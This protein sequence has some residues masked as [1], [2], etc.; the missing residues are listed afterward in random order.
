MCNRFLIESYFK[1][2]VT[3]NVLLC[4]LLLLRVPCIVLCV[5]LCMR[6]CVAAD[7][8]S[9]LL[10]RKATRAVARIQSAGVFSGFACCV[11]VFVCVYMCLCQKLIECSH[12]YSADLCVCFVFLSFYVL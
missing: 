9:V 10:A 3:F 2:C 7:W 5:F 4:E 6:R 11:C 12:L 1:L 8:S